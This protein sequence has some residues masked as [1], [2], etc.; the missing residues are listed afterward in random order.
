MRPAITLGGLALAA[1]LAVQVPLYGDLLEGGG[2]VYKWSQPYNPDYAYA[3]DIATWSDITPGQ[4]PYLVVA[5][6]DDWLCSDDQPVTG[7]DWW[8]SYIGS[9]STTPAESPSYFAIHIFKDVPAGADQSYSHPGQKVWSYGAYSSTE[10]FTGYHDSNGDA[11]FEYSIDINPANWFVQD[12][13]E[14]IYW[15]MII[16]AMVPPA[17][18]EFSPWGWATVPNA[19]QDDG[20]V[21]IYS[22]SGWSWDPLIDP[23]DQS[24]DLAF[25]LTTLGTDIPEPTTLLFMASGM[26]VLAGAM[27]RRLR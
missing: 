2:D 5:A 22:G 10:V 21:G 27:R 14:N 13:G 12:E 19:F 3:I 25:R 1:L 9:E 17:S 8:G 16:A 15:L 26:L 7:I 6:A 11:V 23:E 20:V 18:G 4:P 24:M